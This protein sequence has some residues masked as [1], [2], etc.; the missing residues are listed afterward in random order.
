MRSLS[1]YSTTFNV[2]HN[3]KG[4]AAEIAGQLDAAKQ[5]DLRTNHFSIGGNSAN[6]TQTT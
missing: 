2:N 6:V 3:Y 4:N 1:P 5:K